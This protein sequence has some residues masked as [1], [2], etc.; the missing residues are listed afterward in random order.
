MFYAVMTG[1][2]IFAVAIGVASWMDR[3]LPTYTGTFTEQSTQCDSVF[4]RSRAC[5][6]TGTWVSDDG[7][8]TLHN[9]TLD[10][11]VAPHG[12]VRATYK[13]GGAMKTNDVVHKAT[14]TH[15]ELW[16]PW[17]LAAVILA[18]IAG[19]RRQWRG[20]GQEDAAEADSAPVE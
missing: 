20:R 7:R 4:S 12:T 8:T 11:S 14:R 16:L 9:V 10:G 18:F 17:V 5:T 15:P 19:A 2:F 1:L 6:S 13:P 3:D